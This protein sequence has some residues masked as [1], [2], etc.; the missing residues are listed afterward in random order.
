ML[1]T[2]DLG[3]RGLD[4]SNVALVI[5][6][7]L[8]KHADEYI[9]RIGRTG[10]A[11]SQGIAISLIGKRDWLSFCAI[12]MKLQQA[13]EF[14]TVEGLEAK[15][16]GIVPRKVKSQPSN[17]AENAKEEKSNQRRPVKRTRSKQ[18]L[19]QLPDAGAVPIMRKKPVVDDD[20]TGDSEQ[21]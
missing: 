17:K 4:L 9:H 19:S 5:N 11:G 15:F 12:K 18:D 13:Y 16:S 14:S 3:A 20:D 2:T 6:Y 21:F 1:V 8:P 7:D 10:R